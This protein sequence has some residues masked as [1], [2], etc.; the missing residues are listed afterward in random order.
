MQQDFSIQQKTGEKQLFA[1]P[2]QGISEQKFSFDRTLIALVSSWGGLIADLSINIGTYYTDIETLDKP[3][4]IPFNGTWVQVFGRSD[5]G[6]FTLF[7]PS[8][9]AA[10]F[11]QL[12]NDD[13]DISKLEGGD[14]AL[15]FE[16][17]LSDYFYKL[18]ALLGANL[19]IQTIADVTTPVGGELL[20][21]ELDINGQTTQ[22]AL[23]V[24]GDLHLE[25]ERLVGQNS[26]PEE[27][28]MD[29]RMI[30][31]LGPVV[32][33]ARQAYLARIGEMIDC[34]VEPSDIIKGILMR[35]DGRYWPIHI[36]DEQVEVVGELSGPVDFSNADK[37]T[38]FVTF[39]LGEVSLSA[40]QRS[41]IT[42]GTTIN[43]TRLPNN[44]ANIYYQAR[45]FGQGS[46]SIL[47]TN[48]AV[49]LGNV[50]AFKV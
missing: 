21:F 26:I 28:K 32:L 16:H 1:K 38:V 3:P 11:L 10:S 19:E 9:A 30:V 12:A 20:G 34:G 31:H 44:A 37:D 18:E 4:V 13:L 29:K 27:K 33:P 25:L 14:A 42:T 48:L 22:C 15:V 36:E 50:G 43:V 6:T 2:K 39:G 7:M 8:Q 47:G 45:P 24:T 35:A 41:M 5:I 49:E 46:L 40:Y 23:N 17:L